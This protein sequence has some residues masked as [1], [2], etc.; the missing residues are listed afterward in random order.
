MEDEDTLYVIDGFE[1]LSAQQMFDMTVEH[2]QKTRRRSHKAHYGCSYSGSGCAASV[3]LKPEFHEAADPLGA[4]SGLA[5][6]GKV[7]EHE[8]DFVKELQ[9]AHDFSSDDEF[10]EQWNYRMRDIAEGYGLDTSQ[11][12]TLE[13]VEYFPLAS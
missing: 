1:Q 3:F 4:W 7:P 2:I 10:M 5:R 13:G 6:D 12:E 9:K 8:L 11:L